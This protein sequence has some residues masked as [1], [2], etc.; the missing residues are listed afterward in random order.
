VG[1]ATAPSAGWSEPALDR[2][3]GVV[4]PSNFSSRLAG[5]ITDVCVRRAGAV[6]GRTQVRRC[7]LETGVIGIM[8]S[9]VGSLDAAGAST[10]IRYHA[11]CRTL[12]EGTSCAE[13]PGERYRD[14]SEQRITRATLQ[15]G[16]ALTNTNT[17]TRTQTVRVP[18][19]VTNHLTCTAA[20]ACMG[21]GFHRPVILGHRI[22]RRCS[23]SPSWGPFQFAACH[24]ARRRVRTC[25]METLP[26]R[27]YIDALSQPTIGMHSRVP[28]NE[29]VPGGAR[30]RPCT[31]TGSP[32]WCV[33]NT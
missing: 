22:T 32:R 27:S 11:C 7:G 19:A 6:T 30:M 23:S 18:S 16:P 4:A 14:G 3:P 1:C 13:Y 20:H 28:A 25:D 17:S 2:D 31:T 9:A 12:P 10:N 29:T 24:D 33:W 26:A 5:A 21:R 15:V 8:A